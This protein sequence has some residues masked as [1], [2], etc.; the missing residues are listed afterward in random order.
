MELSDKDALKDFH[1]PSSGQDYSEFFASWT[2]SKII[3][4]QVYRLSTIMKK[5]GHYKLDLLKMDIEGS[6]FMALP[7]IFASGVKVNQLCIE[8]HSRIFPDSTERMR[9]L[10]KLIN[11]NGYVLVSNGRNEQTYIHN[12][13]CLGEQMQKRE[14]T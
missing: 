11:E 1:V 12:T 3:Q 14:I 6:E 2:Q 9:N 5:F 10:R 7:D 4:M 13:C 8:T